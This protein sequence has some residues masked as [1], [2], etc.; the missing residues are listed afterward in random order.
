MVKR[1]RE[2]GHSLMEIV[3][4]L[5]VFGVFLYVVVSLTAEMRRQ[6]KKY[7]VNFLANPEVNAVLVR[8]RRDICDTT[9]YYEEYATVPASDQVLW[10]DT[11]TEAG[12]SEV[13]MWDFRTTGEVHRRVYNSA[14]VQVSEWVIRGVP[15]FS[16]EQTDGPHG[17]KP[18]EV[19][20]IDISDPKHPKLSID[21]IITPRPHP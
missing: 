12:T 6:E 1:R 9:A 3:V 5:A 13:V 10:L 14:Q 19:R 4:V 7:P 21:E 11:I 16:A 8:M 18:I 17:T 2:R 20:A 15:I